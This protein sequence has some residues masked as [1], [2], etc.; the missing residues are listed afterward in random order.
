MDSNNLVFLPVL[1]IVSFL[2][3]KFFLFFLKKSNLNRLLDN[4]YNKPQAFHDSPIAVTG[5]V[6]IFFSLLLVFI[7]LFFFKNVIFFEFLS[8]CTLFFF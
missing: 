3:N 1:V 6:G 5:G 7:Y 2:F 4:Q 8:I